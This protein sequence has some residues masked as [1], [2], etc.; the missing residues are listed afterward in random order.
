MSSR[1]RD[2]A[3]PARAQPQVIKEFADK[4]AKGQTGHERY[5]IFRQLKEQA[6]FSRAKAEKDFEVM[7][8]ALRIGA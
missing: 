3:L 6:E 5:I 1:E 7:R 8:E 2:G 4:N